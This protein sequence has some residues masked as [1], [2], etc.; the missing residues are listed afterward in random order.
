MRRSRDWRGEGEIPSLRF[1]G[2]IRLASGREALLHGLDRGCW[3][4]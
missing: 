2:L 1:A 4:L 3:C